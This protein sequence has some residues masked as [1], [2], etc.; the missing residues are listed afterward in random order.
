M[1]VGNPAWVACDVAWYLQDLDSFELVAGGDQGVG[2]GRDVRAD[3]PHRRGHLAEGAGDVRDLDTRNE[4]A[5]IVLWLV[6]P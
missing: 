5:P 6:T 4:H 2:Y 1:I 3:R